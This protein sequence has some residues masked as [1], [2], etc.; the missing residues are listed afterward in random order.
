[1]NRHITNFD[2]RRP[3]MASSTLSSTVSFGNRLVT[4]NVRAIPSAVRRWLGQL[5]TS[6]PNSSTCPALAG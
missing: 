1:M 6:R 3:V 2:A 5:V 4:W